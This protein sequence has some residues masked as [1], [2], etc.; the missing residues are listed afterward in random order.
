MSVDD[1]ITKYGT[2]R[3]DFARYVAQV[4]GA[5]LLTEVTD[6]PCKAQVAPEGDLLTLLGG[7]LPFGLLP[8]VWPATAASLSSA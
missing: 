3:A 1:L 2:R 6:D 7:C 5:R 8:G 4:D